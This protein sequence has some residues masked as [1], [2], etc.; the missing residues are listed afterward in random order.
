MPGITWKQRKQ[1]TIDYL[2]DCDDTAVLLVSCA[3]KLSNIR[4]IY[5]DYTEIGDKLW[6]RFNAGYKEQKWY[7][8]SLVRSLMRVKEYKMYDEFY[9]TVKKVFGGL[10]VSWF[11]KDDLESILRRM[12]RLNI[13]YVKSVLDADFDVLNSIAP[14][15]REFNMLDDENLKPELRRVMEQMIELFDKAPDLKDLKEYEETLVNTIKMYFILSEYILFN[16]KWV[17]KIT[18]KGILEW[19]MFF[20]E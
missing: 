4:S 9:E 11:I 12:H 8:Q 5:K 15:I 16:L 17:E 18:G 20:Y 10:P 7:Y 1:H 6:D 3:D 14:V 2:N 13:R 19:H